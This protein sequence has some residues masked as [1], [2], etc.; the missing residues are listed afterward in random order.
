[1]K[2]QFA[3]LFF[4]ISAISFAQKTITMKIKENTV[5]CEGV[6]PM[7]C[8]QVKKVRPKNGVIFTVL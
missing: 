5:P 7:N 6:A 1:M 2:L 8:M 3:I 4:S